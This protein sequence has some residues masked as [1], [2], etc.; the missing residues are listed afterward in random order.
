MRTFDDFLE[1]QL[2][3]PEFRE[4]YE[5]LEP[6]YAMKRQIIQ[7]RIDHNLTQAQLAERLGMK[8]SAL[9]RLESG[10]IVPTLRTLQRIA[11]GLEKKLVVTFQ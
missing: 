5:A 2:Q 11:R 9:A 6:L 4:D 1:E 3:D 10:Q 8:Q 7:Y